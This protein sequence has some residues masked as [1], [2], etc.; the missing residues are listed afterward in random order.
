MAEP[1][2]V[3]EE[4]SHDPERD[5]RIL[6]ITELLC[7]QLGVTG[8]HPTFVSWQVYSYQSRPSAPQRRQVFPPDDC[9]LE[10]YCV[11]LSGWVRGQLE[12][13]E[14]KPIIASSIIFS[15]KLRRR[16]FYGFL[17]PAILFIALAVGVMLEFP[18]LFPQPFTSNTS[19]GQYTVPVGQTIGNFLGLILGFMGPILTGTVLARRTR[20]LADEKAADLV[21]TGLFLSTL[22]KIADLTG[23]R[24]RRGG[25][26]KPF[27]LLPS[28][29]RRIARLEQYQE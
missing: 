25:M 10:R 15:K 1:P 23:P 22:R 27:P 12:P 24:W 9:M 2:V 4:L 20:L 18:L 5:P 16:T 26:A 14:W 29:P 11:T 7:Q 3:T 17:I 6:E 8:Y 13:D 19:S 28:L 21:G